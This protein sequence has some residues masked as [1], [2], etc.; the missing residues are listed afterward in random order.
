MTPP[1]WPGQPP[2]GQPPAG[3]PPYGAPGGPPPMPGAP[4]PPMH[5]GAPPPPMHGGPHQPMGGPQGPFPPP[6]RPPSGGGGALVPLLIAGVVLVFVVIGAGAFVILN[7]GEDDPR[8]TITLPTPT[9]SLLPTETP[10]RDTT[11]GSGG[12]PASV[13]KPTLETARGNTFT[14][15]GT[16]RTDSCTARANSTLQTRLRTYPCTDLLHSAMYANSTR[17][18]VTVISVMEL[19]SSAAA[20]G[21]SSAVYSEGWPELLKPTVSSGLPQLDD[22]PAFWTR[23]WTLNNKVIYAQSYWARGGSV[24]DR[25]GSVYT[26]AGELGVE[27]TNVLRFTT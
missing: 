12:D 26:T 11:V 1:E 4:P 2:A 20:T 14:R 17:T 3:Q 7:S 15:V 5:G 13:L 23:T 27:V 10:T 25:S 22:D 6:P 16:T 21:V 19:G 8:R 9:S 24:G 18:I